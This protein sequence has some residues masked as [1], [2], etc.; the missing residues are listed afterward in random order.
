MTDVGTTRVPG[1]AERAAFVGGGVGSFLIAGV[2]GFVLLYL[3]DEVGL[4]AAAVGTMLLVARIL[5]GALDPLLGYAVDHLRATRWGRFRPTALVGT[6]L[7]AVGLVAL[8]TLPSVSPWPLATAWLVYLLWGAALGLMTI[9]LVSLLPVITD[10]L[11]VRSHLAGL[12]G[13]TGLLSSAAVAALTLPLVD[14]LGGGRRG[15]GWYAVVVA[16]F[17][18]CLVLALTALVR[19]R[20]SPSDRGQYTLREVRTVFFSDWAVPCL[21]TCKIVVQSASG[22]LTAVLPFFFLH[23]MGDKDLLSAAAVVMVVPM[24]LGAVLIPRRAHRDGIKPWYLASLGFS[25]AGLGSLL[26]V[27]AD[28]A[29]V[30]L[31]FALTGLG[32]GGAAALNLVLLADLTDEVERRHGYRAE[33]SLAAIMSFATKAGAGLGAGAVA[34]VL[35]LTGYREGRSVQ[36]ASA[37][38]GVLLA[39]SLIPAVL[40]LLGAAVF[41]TYPLTRSAD[42]ASRPLGSAYPATEES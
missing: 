42:R 34:Y 19:E 18:L 13:L 29:P 39:Q 24:G 15:W 25:I 3:T 5:D 10:D 17:G 38:H 16:V 2:A 6:A 31:C 28:P 40:G 36:T 11:R 4:G 27:P 35:A 12:V 41:L 32:F 20:V 8:F 26:L 7:S 21:L 22:A 9:P 23:Y 1:R 30:L 14:L 33:A 37:I